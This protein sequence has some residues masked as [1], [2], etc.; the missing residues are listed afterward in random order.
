MQDSEDDL[1]RDA[2]AALGSCVH[3]PAAAKEE[4]RQTIAAIK[5]GVADME[6]GRMQP[7]REILE[8]ARNQ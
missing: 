3:S 4:Y 5:Q 8:E 6:A 7:L 2:L 1:L